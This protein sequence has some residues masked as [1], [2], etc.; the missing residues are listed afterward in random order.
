M[1]KQYN[2]IATRSDGYKVL[3]FSVANASFD[4]IN[5]EVSST[6]FGNTTTVTF[7]NGVA[8]NVSM[9]LFDAAHETQDALVNVSNGSQTATGQ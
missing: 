2:D 1:F 9:S 8:E 5:P 6:E 3:T 7:N 4:G